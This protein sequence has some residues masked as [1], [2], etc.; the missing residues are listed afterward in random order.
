MSRRLLFLRLDCLLIGEIHPISF[1][2]EG[3]CEALTVQKS[4]RL[5]RA[6]GSSDERLHAGQKLRKGKRLGQIIVTACLEALDAV[7]Y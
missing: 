1:S 7:I 2:S 6:A 3:R 5:C 4:G